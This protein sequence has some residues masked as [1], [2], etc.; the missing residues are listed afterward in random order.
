M[1]WAAFNTRSKANVVFVKLLFIK[2][3]V[4]ATLHV[5]L[6]ICSPLYCLWICTSIRILKVLYIE[7]SNDVSIIASL[8]TSS[9]LLMRVF[10]EIRKIFRVN[11]TYR[12]LSAIN[13]IKFYPSANINDLQIPFPTKKQNQTNSGKAR[14]RKKKRRKQQ[15]IFRRFKLF[16]HDRLRLRKGKEEAIRFFID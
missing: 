1:I 9:S 7:L 10:Y 5:V 3:G 4:F 15:R 11:Q 6:K 8:K 12:Y 16:N 2:V 13:L 14:K